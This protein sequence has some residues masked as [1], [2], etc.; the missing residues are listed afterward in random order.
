MSAPDDNLLAEIG[1]IAAALESL[2]TTLSRLR[3]H[4]IALLITLAISTVFN[5]LFVLE[6]LNG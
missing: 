5:I 4:C 6:L 1:Q 2:K 3:V